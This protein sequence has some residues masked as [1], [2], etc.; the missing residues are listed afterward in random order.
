MRDR[1]VKTSNVTRFMAGLTAIQQRG[2]GE[3]CLM[4]VDGVPGVSKST[5]V[6]W[7]AV[8]EDAILIR[9]KTK[10][11]AAWLLRDLMEALGI[12]DEARKTEDM[13]R[14]VVQALAVR[15]QQAVKSGR[16]FGVA[17]DEIDHVLSERR[18]AEEILETLR[19]L[20]DILEI[21]TILVGM[22]RVR[23]ALSKHPQITSRVGAY[24]EFL[25]ADQADAAAMVRDLCDVPV[26]DCLIGCLLELSGGLLREIKEG[27]ARIERF[28]TRNG[29]SPDKPVTRAA[30][31]GQLLLNDRATGKP[32]HV[33]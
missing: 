3:A 10:Y 32:L 13:Y 2:A 20:S 18:R 16:M 9:A 30:M 27:I 22:D 5:V 24:V 17:V 7:W 12:K 25:P 1:F 21:P 28:G 4:V 31:T 14:R 6:Q 29:A 11:T 8:Q 33:R 26:A 15:K 23:P 19:D